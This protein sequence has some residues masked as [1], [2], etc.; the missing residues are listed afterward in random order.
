MNS[1]AATERVLSEDVLKH[2]YKCEQNN[3]RPTLE[4]IAGVL[5]ITP[6]EVSTLVS[7]MVS[8]NLL[9]LENGEFHLT[10]NGQEYGLQIIRAHRLWER[11]LA[12]E[13]G[14]EEAEWHHLAEQKE[15]AMTPNE[16]EALA[17]R[18]GHPTHDPHGDPI[19][20]ASGDFVPHGGQPLTAL[21]SGSPAKIVH[22]EDEPPV[23]YA[24]LVAEGLYPGMEVQIKEMTP[25]RIRFISGGEEH[26]LAP[27]VAGNISVSPL[28]ESETG[29]PTQYQHLSNLTIGETGKV[30]G[31][32][33]ACRG[34]ERHRFMDLGILPGTMITAEM[35]SPGGDPTAYLIRR[36]LI[37]LRKEQADMI[38]IVSTGNGSSQKMETAQ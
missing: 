1:I 16:V 22:I 15:H 5:Q 2:V 14:F 33:P 17:A 25:Q 30:I 19:P 27:V 37:G 18:L 34:A 32:S 3:R 29:E 24:Q 13:T 9:T 21:A 31:I 28:N 35:V 23:V 12:D 20:T 8:H 4:S 38:N 7:N 11:Y 36:S 26:I 10:P 6:D